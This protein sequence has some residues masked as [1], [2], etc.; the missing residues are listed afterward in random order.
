MGLF[1]QL[2]ILGTLAGLEL[3]QDCPVFGPAYPEVTNPGASAVFSA[4]KTAID[5]EIAK[6]LASG[7]LANETYFAVQTLYRIQPLQG[8]ERLTPLAGLGDKRWNDPVTMRIPELARLKI[9]IP[10]TTSTGRKPPSGAGYFSTAAHLTALGR[11]ILSSTLLRP[12]PTR[13]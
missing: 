1:R 6:A 4:A 2:V 11:S 12:A 13:A 5:D 3:S 8:C 10:S 7:Q 9:Q